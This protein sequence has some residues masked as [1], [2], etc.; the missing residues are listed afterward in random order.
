MLL[1]S[2]G[3]PPTQSHPSPG[4]CPPSFLPQIPALLAVLSLLT[5]NPL[6]VL[7]FAP[8]AALAALA[9]YWWRDQI[10]LA[11][12]L[13]GVAAHGLAA[14]SGVITATFL[15]NIGSILA[16]SPLA[17]FIGEQGQNSLA[18]LL[19][20]WCSMPAP[21]G[22]PNAVPMPNWRSAL[23]RSRPPRPLPCLRVGFAI[24]NGE[25]VPNPQRSGSPQCVTTEGLKVS[26]C[27][28]HNN[29]FAQAYFGA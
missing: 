16:I 25:A 27:V 13:L 15:L 5:F 26:C 1:D 24:M 9:F 6:G 8:V 20:P 14:N 4:A 19:R 22:S 10:D 3:H 18:P 21:T 7:I 2:A 28:W 11:T 17:V 12:R 23:L 29:A